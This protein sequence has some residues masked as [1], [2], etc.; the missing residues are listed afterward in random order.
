MPE[1]CAEPLVPFPGLSPFPPHTCTRV[2]P[3]LEAVCSLWTSVVVLEA[4][5]SPYSW[6]CGWSSGGACPHPLPPNHNR[7]VM[8]AGTGGSSTSALVGRTGVRP[9]QEGAI[10]M[11]ESRQVGTRAGPGRTTGVLPFPGPGCSSPPAKAMRDPPCHAPHQPLEPD[12]RS[13]LSVQSWEPTY[14]I[15][16]PVRALLWAP[17]LQGL[18]EGCPGDTKHPAQVCITLTGK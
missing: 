16:G 9:H 8:F 3:S 18:P 6:E 4:R 17:C 10:N 5:G 7:K 1:L 13:L 14:P 11:A 2:V 12:S 15:M